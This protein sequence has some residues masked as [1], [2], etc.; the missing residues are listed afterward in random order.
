MANKWVHNVYKRLRP[1][2]YRSGLIPFLR[3]RL[4]VSWRLGLSRRLGLQDFD[5]MKI[6]PQRPRN[7]QDDVALNGINFVGDLQVEIGIGE[8]TRAIYKVLQDTELPLNYIEVALPIAKRPPINGWHSHTTLTKHYDISIIHLNP[9]EMPLAFENIP[10][11]ATKNAYTIGFWYWELPVF[12]DHW[13]P[14][15]HAVDEVWVASRYT[16]SVL[17]QKSPV[18]VHH[19]PLPINIQTSKRKTRADFALP[20]DRF[21]FL[22]SFSATSSI[23][24]KNPFTVIEAFRRAF[25]EDNA[26]GPLLVIKAH[27]LSSHFGKSLAGP[28]HQAMEKIGGVCINYN[29]SR[30]DMN[31]FM[32]TCDCFVSLHRA[33]GF[34]LHLAE[35]M[36]LGKPV[37]ATAFSGNMDF[38]TQANSYGVDYLLRT[39]TA[40]DHQ[41]SNLFQ[42]VYPDELVWAE[43]DIDH[44]AK[45]MRHVYDHQAEAKRVGLQAQ[46]DITSKLTDAH[47]LHHIHQRL[48]QITAKNDVVVE[49]PAI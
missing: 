33:E 29:F 19:M 45:L 4:P 31:D 28:L 49:C 20:E 35:A 42:K 2:L 34:G 12:P 27:H 36:A 15:F 47:T 21:I 25:G 7:S 44:A 6:A 1:I 24:R 16:Q 17:R 32:D 5:L 9:P 46:A 23:G 11:H 22:F 43:P 10:P 18:P 37:I 39:I 30:Q 13:L 14:M 41:F 38:M 26:N 8:S 3:K 40:A 48:N